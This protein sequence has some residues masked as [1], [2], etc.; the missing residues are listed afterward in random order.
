MRC[1][2]HISN[3]IVQD[4]LAVIGDEIDRIRDSVAFWTTTPKR[5]QKFEETTHQLVISSMKQ[6][7]LGC[8]TWWN[9]TYLM[10]SVVVLYKDVF[11]RLKAMDSQYKC[12]PKERD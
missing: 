11:R 3:F 2:A 5:E 8:M 12:L 10:L 4:G 1:A 6:L 9:S 7:A